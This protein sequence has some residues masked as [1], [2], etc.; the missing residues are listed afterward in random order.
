MRPL[1]VWRKWTQRVAERRLLRAAILEQLRLVPGERILRILCDESGA[2]VVL[3]VRALYH[4]ADGSWSRIGWEQVLRVGSD[5]TQHALVV[6]AMSPQGSKRTT[7]RMT[8]PGQLLDLARER[9][10]STFLLSTRASLGHHGTALI[11][12][13]R[14]PVAGETV[15]HVILDEHV[16][17]AHPAVDARIKAV[18]EELRG[19]LGQ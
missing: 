5:D 8:D 16:D 2:W 11:T 7:L 4:Q 17:R 15:W 3:T 14:T 6:T 1:Q 9:I 10:A 19:H 12:A 13:R 18:I